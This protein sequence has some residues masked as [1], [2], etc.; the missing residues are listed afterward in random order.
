MSKKFI[1]QYYQIN[2][3]RAGLKK[4][5]LTIENVT[6]CYCEKGSKVQNK[7]SIIFI[8]GFSSGKYTWLNVIKDIPD[9][10]HCIAIDMPG[11]G[12]TVGFDEEQLIAGVIVDNLKLFFDKLDMIEPMCLVG[13]SMGGSIVAMFASKYPSYVKMI[14]LLAPVPPGKQYETEAIRQLRSG[15]YDLVL[16]TTHKQFYTTAKTLTMRK[17]RFRRL[18]AN[19]YLKSRLTMLDQ[20][21]KLLKS[22][23]EHDYPNLEESYAPL[24]ELT[25]PALIIWGRKD[26]LCA[27]EGA[28]YFVNLIPNTELIMFEDCGHLITNDKPQETTKSIVNFWK[29]HHSPDRY[30]ELD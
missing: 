23:F 24:K 4:H 25:C 13:T 8:H 16:P 7:A 2:T 22:A 3:H 27:V 20:H 28:D 1:K 15:V 14:C 30:Y 9:S 11:H 6:F 26:E 17:V 29:E 12:E 21:R 10:F 18:L 5:Y 19:G